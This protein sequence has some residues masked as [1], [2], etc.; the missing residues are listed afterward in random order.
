MLLGKGAKILKSPRAYGKV[1]NGAYD[2]TGDAVVAERY[3]CT[4]DEERSMYVTR[5]DELT[6]CRGSVQQQDR[7][8][9]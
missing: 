1:A 9:H 2:E 5:C 4:K 3:R 7:R 8:G 6:W